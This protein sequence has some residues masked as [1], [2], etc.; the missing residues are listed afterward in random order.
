MIVINYFALN[1]SRKGIFQLRQW[2]VSENSIL[3]KET[4]KSKAEH[5]TDTSYRPRWLHFPLND[6]YFWEKYSST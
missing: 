6:A 3:K 4:G 2:V 1:L 5:G